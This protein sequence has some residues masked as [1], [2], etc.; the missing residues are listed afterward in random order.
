MIVGIDTVLII[1]DIEGSS[2]CWDYAASCFRTPE[3]ASAC[4]EMSKDIDAVCAALFDKGVRRVFVSDFHRTG[5]NLMPELIDSRARIMHGYRSGPVPGI[6][7]PHGATTL[8]M[9]GMH[10]P[11]GSGGFLAHTMTSRISRLEVNGGLMSE[12]ELFASSLAPFGVRP[13]FIS[14]CPEAC[15]HAAEILPGMVTCA[16]DKSA[17]KEGFDFAG[18]RA[19]LSRYAADSL[20]LGAAETYEPGGP[21]YVKV[22]MRDGEGE[23]R[24]LARRWGF[25]SKG[26]EI[27]I[28]ADTMGTLYH[29]L[30]RICYLTPMAERALPIA[31]GLF[32]MV[33]KA[34]LRWARNHIARRDQRFSN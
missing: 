27:V 25:E 31:L 2:G 28:I 9:V 10:A 8:L 20:R 21:F 4:V 18:W 15:R 3:W 7:D 17:G 11:S 32:N 19:A 6:G 33:G 29:S 22:V 24:R 26:D 16:I 23:A 12:A 5:Y 14:G 34:G 13:V 30:I 1:S